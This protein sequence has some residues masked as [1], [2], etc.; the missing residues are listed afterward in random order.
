MYDDKPK[1]PI[2]A[3]IGA[4]V[5]GVAAAGALHDYGLDFVVFDHLKDPR[6]R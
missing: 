2:V 1:Q 5:A 6:G 4:G 3:I